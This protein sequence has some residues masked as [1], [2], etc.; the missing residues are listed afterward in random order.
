VRANATDTEGRKAVLKK[1]I[2]DGVSEA[3]KLNANETMGWIHETCEKLDTEKQE[4]AN[5]FEY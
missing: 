4:A 1:R 5:E 2:Q 3:A